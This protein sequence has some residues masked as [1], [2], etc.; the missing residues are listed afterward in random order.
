MS[1]ARV[2]RGYRSKPALLSQLHG[3]GATQHGRPRTSQKQCV[4]A[5]L[6][7][8]GPPPITMHNLQGL[9]ELR[10]A[11]HSQ[12]YSITH[13]FAD[14]LPFGGLSGPR[15]S[16]DRHSSGM[17][18]QAHRPTAGGAWVGRS[19]AMSDWCVGMT[20]RPL[21]CSSVAGRAWPVLCV[22]LNWVHRPVGF[23][24]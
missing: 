18:W 21:V 15:A 7:S 3:V 9:C 8:L 11:W 14:G 4:A 12:L 17:Q 23:N 20:G 22:L 2:R 10:G 19:R 5:D 6:E 16:Y 1:C 24:P 13:P